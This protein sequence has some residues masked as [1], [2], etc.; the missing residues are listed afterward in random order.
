MTDPCRP[1]PPLRLHRWRDPAV[2]GVGAVALGAG[3]GQFGAVAALGDVARAFGHLA[4]GTTLADQAGLSGTEIG[5]GLAV[6]RLASMFS[7]PVAGMADRVGRR[8]LLVGGC[9]VGLAVTA[10]ASLSPS[11]WWFVAIFALGR[12]FLGS[13]AA[14]CQVVA[15]E[16][17]PSGERAK[18]VAL[19]AGA[20]AVGAG[21]TAVIHGLAGAGLGFRGLFALAVVPLVALPLVSRPV[22]EPDRYTLASQQDHA[23]LPV[24][25]PVGRQF[26]GRLLAVSCLGFLVAVVTGPAN[27]F[28]FLYSENVVGLS[29]ALVSAMVVVAGA[30]GLG[31]L[32]AGRWAADRLGRRIT[33]AVGMVGIALFGLLAYSGPKPSLLVGYVAG[34][35]AGSVF[36]PAAGALVNE[37]F[38]TGVRASVAGWQVM[39]GVMGAVAGLVAFGAIADLGNRFSLAAAAVFLPALPGAALFAALPETR[40]MEPE[41]MWR[42]DDAA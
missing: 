1:G 30:V 5:L 13:S 29:G 19:V 28:L 20:Y 4:H 23:P 16:Q 33:G 22:S 38:P 18:A 39:A 25:G 3:F 9:A 10:A 27:S 15:A 36:T 8:R 12:P 7:L 35:L 2:L 21:L 42:S 6:L 24:L 26:R 37:L 14:L 11:F 31:G 17:T 32:L 41:Q 34:V 40:G